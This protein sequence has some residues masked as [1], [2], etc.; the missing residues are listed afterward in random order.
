[1]T[2]DD[3]LERLAAELYECRHPRTWEACPEPERSL[4]RGDAGFVLPGV[5]AFVAD[6]LAGYASLSPS[7]TR[8]IVAAWRE[9]MGA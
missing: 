1:V 6:W 2:G 3:L 8:E 4:Y 9:E 7:E 5:V